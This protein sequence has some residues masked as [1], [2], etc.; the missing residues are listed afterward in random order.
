MKTTEILYSIT[1]Y[2]YLFLACGYIYSQNS[3][4]IDIL[5]TEQGLPFRAITCIAQDKNEAIWFGTELGLIRYDGYHFKVYNSDKRNPFYI[6]DEQIGDNIEIDH[7]TNVFWYFANSKLYNLDLSSDKVTAFNSTHNIIGNVIHLLKTSDGSIWINTDDYLTAEKGQAKHYLQKYSNGKFEVKATI[8]RN[9]DGYCRLIEDKKG[10]ILLSVSQGTL[11]FNSQGELQDTYHLSTVNLHGVK[12]NYTVSY[13]DNENMHYFLPQKELGIFSFNETDYSSKHLFKD[14]IQFYTAIQDHQNHIWFAGN[15]ELYRMDSKGEFTNY[16]QQLKSR[17][18]YSKIND[19]FIDANN[20]LWVATDNGLFKIRIGEGLFT[21]LFASKNQGWGNTMRG[22]FEDT[23]GTIF[24]K[25]ESQNKL[26]Y[27]TIDGKIDTLQLGLDPSILEDSQYVSNFYALDQNQKNIFTLGQSLMKIN[28][29]NGTTKIYD[30]YKSSITFKGQNPLIKLKSGELLFGQ[31]L[32]R[33][34]LFDPE[35]ETSRLLFENKNVKTDFAD[36]RYFK[37]SKTDSVVWIGTRSDGLLKIHLSGS[38]EHVYSK[39]TNPSISRNYILVIDEDSEGNLWVGTYGGG[40]NYISADTKTVKAYTKNQGLPNDNVVGI[41]FDEPNNI[42]VSTYNGLAV[43]NKKTEVFQNFYAEDG[44]T[45]YEFNYSSFFK[46]SNGIFYFGGMN[47]LNSFKPNEVLKQSEPPEMRFTEASGYNS[48]NKSDFKIDF[49]QTELTALKVSPY[50]Q[51]FEIN[52]TMPSYF[53]NTKNTYST[54]LEGFEDRW[55]YQGNNSKVRYNQLPAGHYV[56]KIKGKDSRGVAS[57]SMLSIPIIVEQ[58]FYKRWWFLAIIGL[59]II[60]VMYAIFRYRLQQVLAM[61]LLRIK[62]SS[63]LHDDVG[64]MLSGLAMQTEL[65]ELNANEA[66]KSKL[67]KIA[68][69]SRNAISQMRDLVWSIDSRRETTN[70]L[71]E[72]MQ[73]LAEEL[74]LPKEISFQFNHSTVIYPN[75]KLSSQIKQNIFL[76]YKEAITNILRHSDA[77]TVEI[78]FRN[79]NKG[80]ELL[81]K[82]DGSKKESYKST[83]LG[84]SNMELRAKAINSTV[85]FKMDD[86]FSVHLNLSFN[87]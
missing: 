18:E 2:V 53:Q 77:S 15:T 13:F 55:F 49:S 41:L 50:D 27:K 76:I 31:S 34:V 45:H 16:T 51:Y 47:G 69:I 43:F 86:G 65:M 5:T 39:D 28:L 78:T 46:D 22:I 81:I 12:S 75:R 60:G 58:I 3:I 37:E 25:C 4:Q 44:L 40:L 9:Q 73:E 8:P 19:L 1:I 32:T 29:K 79:Y 59:I 52:W 7:K 10:N 83:G 80:C 21:P 24:A 33:L 61:E 42:W 54:N 68:G 62:I 66:D 57:S 70:D 17:L 30:D 56:L 36:F 11:K 14:H 71:I 72:R 84:L 35:T 20:L 85:T 67:Q 82:D 26:L 38:L 63:D 64:S 48:K 87:L 23:N 74:L 6:E